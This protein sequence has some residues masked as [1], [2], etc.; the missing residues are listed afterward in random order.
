[1]FSFFTGSRDPQTDA[2]ASSPARPALPASTPVPSASPSS[3][4]TSP[5]PPAASEKPAF[6]PDWYTTSRFF[7][8]LTGQATNQETAE[9]IEARSIANEEK[10]CGRCEEW[11]DW[12]LAQSPTAIFLRQK[13][14]Q[15]GADINSSNVHCRRCPSLEGRKFGAFDGQY[16]VLLC[17]NHL[18]DR[19][20]TEDV[21]AHEMVHAWDYLRFDWDKKDLRHAACA[22]VCLWP[23]SDQMQKVTDRR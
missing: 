23:S 16:G 9:Y 11:R 12:I 8:I 3:P 5:A 14:N 21:L 10:Q 6:D 19:S 17:A 7:S 13:I 22:E 4:P 18:R 2:K 15:L 20:H 1:M